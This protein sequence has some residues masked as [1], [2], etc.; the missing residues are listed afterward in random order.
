MCIQFVKSFS[1]YMFATPNSHP[2][3]FPHYFGSLSSWLLLVLRS[4]KHLH[5]H[6]SVLSGETFWESLKQHQYLGN[7][8]LSTSFLENPKVCIALIKTK[9]LEVNY[10]WLWSRSLIIVCRTVCA[11]RFH[12]SASSFSSKT[13]DNFFEFHFW[14][15]KLAT[16]C[17]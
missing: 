3:S 9:V 4:M 15:E 5:P 14:R 8:V 7:L 10:Y 6:T 2:C 12:V 11:K 17:S 13:S 1:F 16:W